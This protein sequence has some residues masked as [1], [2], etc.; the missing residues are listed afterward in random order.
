M[1]LRWE[2]F[3]IV[4]IGRSVLGMFA[5][6][7]LGTLS[8]YFWWVM[9]PPRSGLTALTVSLVTT[10]GIVMA[11][12]A[13]ITWYKGGAAPGSRAIA[14]AL[15]LAGSLAGAWAGYAYGYNAGL[16]R[17]IDMYGHIPGGKI[18]IP[19]DTGIRWA[20][21][22]GALSANGAAFAYHIYR[23]ARFRDHF[24]Y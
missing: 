10:M 22:V 23:T 16:E 21:G 8:F 24:E 12:G 9:V 20:V 7:V 18:Q 15:I 13:A 14:A 19:T 11:I 17:L 1:T 3:L 4:T 5:A 6:F 2:I